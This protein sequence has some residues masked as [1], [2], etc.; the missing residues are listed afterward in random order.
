MLHIVHFQYFIYFTV[1]TEYTL[2]PQM[3]DCQKRERLCQWKGCTEWNKP[4]WQP[5]SLCRQL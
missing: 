1:T 2:L 5:I 4:S 3:K